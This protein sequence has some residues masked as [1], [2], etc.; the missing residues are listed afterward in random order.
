VAKSFSV[1]TMVDEQCRQYGLRM[2]ETPVGFKH[3]CR[4][5]TE[6]DILIAGEESGGLGVKGHLPER[7]GVYVGL[8]LCEMMAV[9]GKP[10]SALV[11]ELMEEYGN[12]VFKRAD[13]HV[14][15]REKKRII[16]RFRKGLRSIAGRPVTDRKDIDGFKYFIERGWL[17]VR[18]SGTE[19]LVRV[20]AEAEDEQ[21]VDSMLRE[22][23]GIS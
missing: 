15:E 6:R 18:A 11:S 23:A 3:L 16:A 17:L 10:L 12:H 7:D 4:L 5:M 1:T 8:L 21:T 22:A 13:L 2:H 9:R 20:Y 19:P 14:S